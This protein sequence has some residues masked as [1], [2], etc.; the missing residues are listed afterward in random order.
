MVLLGHRDDVP[1]LLA[2]A[3]VAVLTSRWEA[4]A[5]FAQQALR[6]GVPLVVTAVGGL[7]EL[8]ADAALTVP[9][10]R[11]DRV[12]EAIARI[13]DEPGVAAG[14]RAAGP[15]AARSWPTES[16]TAAALRSV[17]DELLLLDS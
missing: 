8:V 2:A 14:L 13:F 17:Y 16:D 11:P 1:A 6:A 9:A 12:A 3:D 4:R 5:L 15:R 7:P 10:G